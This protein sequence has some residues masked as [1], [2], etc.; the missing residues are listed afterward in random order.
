M[1]DNWA[2]EDIIQTLGLDQDEDF[3]PDEREVPEV[4]L[5]IQ[6]KKTERLPDHSIVSALKK[7]TWVG[8][9]ANQ[10]DSHHE[11]EWPIIDKVLEA[12]LKPTTEE[13][14]WIAPTLPPLPPISCTSRA[15]DLIRQR[16]S[17]QRFDG[18]TPLNAE[19]FY[20][21]LDSTLPRN[22]V[23]PWDVFP[24]QPRL[25]LI[26]FVHRIAG[27]SP[28]LYILLRHQA[29]EENLRAVLQRKE[30]DWKKPDNC[31]EHINFYQLLSG[32]AQVTAQ[33]LSCH[34]EIAADSALSLGML[35]EFED[36]LQKGPWYYRRLFWEAGIIG[37][38]LYLEAE[39]VGVRGTGIGCY[40]DDAVHHLLGLND[41]RYQSLYHFT[42]GT[43]LDDKRL[44]TLPPYAHLENK[45]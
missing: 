27:L 13:V 37:Q 6:P 31:P 39:A 22:G 12:T 21:L 44:Q 1:L 29:S 7:V 15:A 38:I 28:G 42:I 11:D 4:M 17:A 41:T 43:P 19:A 30:F 45:F 10:L 20:R 14:D 18:K 33:Q 36:S 8:G 26:L 32:N 34:Q 23:M 5:C 2:D 25:H 9:K 24:H 16:R 40:F 35:A 3:Y